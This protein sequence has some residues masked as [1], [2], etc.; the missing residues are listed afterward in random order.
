MDGS[1]STNSAAPPPEPAEPGVSSAGLDHEA[2]THAKPGTAISITVNVDVGLKF[3]KIVL[4]Y[5]PN[6]SADYL[7]REM[8]QV[9]PGIFSA[10]IPVRATTG[11]L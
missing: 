1:A 5:R 7:G 4:A 9:D 6:G 8:K 11:T 2:V 10:E 3:E